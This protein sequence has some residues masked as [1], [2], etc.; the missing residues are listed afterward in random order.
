MKTLLYLI[1]GLTIADVAFT[2]YGLSLGVIEEA[3]PLMV[4]GMTSKPFITGVT[5]C[6]S[7]A[8]L[9]YLIYRHY[10]KIKWLKWA[11][12]GLLAVKLFI[13]A[14][15]AFWIYQAG[16]EGVFEWLSLVK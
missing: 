10:E 13:I 2:I 4:R 8:F 15:H 9:L 6:I 12:R 3:N 11:V 1:L 14:V 5:V 16:R 7:V